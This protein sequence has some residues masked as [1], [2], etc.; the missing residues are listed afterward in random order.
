[1]PLPALLDPGRLAAI[2]VLAG[3]CA[4]GYRRLRRIVVVLGTRIEGVV[5]FQQNLLKY[6][7]SRGQDWN[8]YSSMMGVADQLQR[9]TGTIGLAS[10]KPRGATYVYNQ[11]PVV[12]N[13]LVQ[14]RT[15]WADDFFGPRWA[16]EDALGLQD[17]LIRYHGEISRSREQAVGELRSPGRWFVEGVKAVVIAPARALAAF[18]LLKTDTEVSLGKTLVVRIASFVVGLV[19]LV[20]GLVTIL[21]GWDATARALHLQRHTDVPQASQSSPVPKSTPPEP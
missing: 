3:L 17:V 18:G 15:D 20:S 9:E 13:T 6:M 14:L 21:G 10:Y 12:L 19:A 5:T 4:I 7:N 1:M 2:A 16:G 11:Y 8:A